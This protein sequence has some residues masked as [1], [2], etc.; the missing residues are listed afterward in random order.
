MVRTP[1]VLGDPEQRGWLIAECAMGC[2]PSSENA[3]LIAAA[4]ELLEAARPLVAMT[5]TEAREAE[6][7]SKRLMFCDFDSLN[8]CWDKDRAASG[9]GEHGPGRHWGG[10][11]S[12]KSCNL[13][14]AIA[15]ATGEAA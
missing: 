9:W 8:P 14:A 15:K 2:M 4:P 7:H 1:F 3:R 10:G 12:C 13:R 6:D 11:L 5:F